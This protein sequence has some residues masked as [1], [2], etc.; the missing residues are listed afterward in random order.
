M[1]HTRTH[2]FV[3]FADPYLA[4]G[5][6]EQW[7][8][9]WHDDD[10]CGCDAGSWLEPC[11]HTA[12]ATSKCPSWGTD[13]AERYV[14]R[15]PKDPNPNDPGFCFC[16]LGLEAWVHTDTT[17]YVEVPLGSLARFSDP[18]TGEA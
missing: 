17:H 1:T 7:V 9:G 5:Q 14:G 8:T 18:G 4:C 6:C 3:T 10:R 16:G 13:T 2:V 11:G 12:E 15:H